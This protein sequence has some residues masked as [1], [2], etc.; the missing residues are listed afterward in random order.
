A[1]VNYCTGLCNLTCNIKPFYFVYFGMQD[2]QFLLYGAY[3]YTGELIARYASEYNLK[4][5]LAGRRKEALVPLAEKLNLPY[6][7]IDLN[8]A[9]LLEAALREVKVVVHCAGPFDFTAK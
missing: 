4:P 3:G 6:K 5:V 2:N 8:N 7:V 9:P 1:L